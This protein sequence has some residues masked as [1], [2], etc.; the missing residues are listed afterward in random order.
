[1]DLQSQQAF[2]SYPWPSRGTS[3]PSSRRAC[4][5]NRCTPTHQ[6]PKPEGNKQATYLPPPGRTCH[7]R[8]PPT[9]CSTTCVASV[10]HDRRGI[11]APRRCADRRFVGAFRWFGCR[12]SL[13]ERREEDKRRSLLLNPRS[14]VEQGQRWLDRLG[15]ETDRKRLTGVMVKALSYIDLSRRSG[16]GPSPLLPW[17]LL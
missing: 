13:A 16:T 4:I 14:S 1:V 12:H 9:A 10:Q 5:D 8:M 11:R 15:V 6:C 3:P 2:V 17:F 7:Q